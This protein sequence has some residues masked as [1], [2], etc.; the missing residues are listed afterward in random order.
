MRSQPQSASPR[1]SGSRKVCLISHLSLVI[2]HPG[3]VTIRKFFNFDV[4]VHQKILEWGLAF[5]TFAVGLLALIGVLLFTWS[6]ESATPWAVMGPDDWGVW[7]G[8]IGM[9]GALFGTIFLATTETRRRHQEKLV[10]AHLHA[11]A[12][13]ARIQLAHNSVFVLVRTLADREDVDEIGPSFYQER[14]DSLRSLKLWTVS[15]LVHLVPLPHNTATKL[16]QAVDQLHAIERLLKTAQAER[17]DGTKLD[18][19]SSRNAIL[20]RASVVRL[21]LRDAEKICRKAQVT[22]ESDA[23]D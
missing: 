3:R 21:Q 5:L 1:A 20:G 16:A 18:R 17:F 13:I 10:L 6:I 22:V 8:S 11:A 14:L 12:M 15:D 23:P 2:R 9:V 19:I 4:F 7:V